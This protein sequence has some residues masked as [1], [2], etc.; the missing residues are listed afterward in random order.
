VV[1]KE[2]IGKRNIN[3]WKG[4]KECYVIPYGVWGKDSYWLHWTGYQYCKWFERKTL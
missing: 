2:G 3:I 4:A 1:L